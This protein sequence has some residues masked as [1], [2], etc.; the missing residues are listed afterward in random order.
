MAML[1]YFAVVDDRR[2]RVRRIIPVLASAD[3]D[4]TMSDSQ[5]CSPSDVDK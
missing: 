1:E 5:R 2:D 3:A 4:P